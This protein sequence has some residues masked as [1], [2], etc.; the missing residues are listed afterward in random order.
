[1][2]QKH[3][4]QLT[5]SDWEK[6]YLS[7]G[8]FVHEFSRAEIHAQVLLQLISGTSQ[9]T[10]K[11]IF[12]GVKIDAVCSFIRRIFEARGEQFPEL[13]E[14]G[15]SQLIAINNVRNSIV[16]YGAQFDGVEMYVSNH[17]KALPG[18]ERRIP[19]TPTTL[20]HLWADLQTI[21]CC[22]TA[23]IA[24][25]LPP[26]PVPKHVI[27]YLLK[28]A[29]VPWRYKPPSQQQEHKN[30]QTRALRPKRQRQQKPSPK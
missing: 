15:F 9:Q 26:T 18:K 2:T 25:T 17:F 3:A 7:L 23:Y 11:A 10:A 1:M 27:E 20:E 6:Y 14:R 22:M 4:A 5:D 8:R 28:G 19:I 12:S 21:Q 30:P 16:H 29:H 13:L 24:P